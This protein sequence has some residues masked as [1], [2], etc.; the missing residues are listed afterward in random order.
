MVNQK[1]RL[2]WHKRKHALNALPFGRYANFT[3]ASAMLTSSY[4]E[5]NE[6]LPLG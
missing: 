5:K 1:T 4:A 2:R 6:V 3:P